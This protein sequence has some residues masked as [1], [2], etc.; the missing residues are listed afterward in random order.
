MTLKRR[1]GETP[2]QHGQ[3]VVRERRDAEARARYEAW[4]AARKRSSQNVFIARPIRPESTDVEVLSLAPT[5]SVNQPGPE[6]PP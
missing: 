6:S 3:R 2:A 5:A 4:D 1:D